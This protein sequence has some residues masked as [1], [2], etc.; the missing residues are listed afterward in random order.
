MEL[1]M[2]VACIAIRINLDFLIMRKFFL[3]LGIALCFFCSAFAQKEKHYEVLDEAKLIV[4][5]NLIW[6]DDSTNL[7]L[8]KQEDM[9]LLIGND[10]SS[11]QSLGYYRY[12]EFQ[13]M[14]PDASAIEYKVMVQETASNFSYRI[15][16]NYPKN[17][18]TVMER[19]P[20]MGY[21][22]YDEDLP[23]F[24]WEI[25]E[26]TIRIEGYLAQKA[27]CQYS[28]RTWEAWF[29]E[30]LPFND[31][32]Y[33]FCGLPGLILNMI[34]SK[35]DYRFYFQSIEVPEK[36][37]TIKWENKE[38]VKTTKKGLFK[39]IDNAAESV[40][41]N[42][43]ERTSTEAQKNIYYGMKANNNPIELDRK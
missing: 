37:T 8:G 36:G 16:K 35:K 39:V 38:T 15:Y 30:E 22:E 1:L 27:V 28:G 32:P 14:S 6:R 18:I 21:F 17:R 10:I 26:D 20:F 25:M 43:D 4:N 11:F 7:K 3:S 33:K 13:M 23:D 40:M 12:R 29:T 34:D 5:Y 2:R 19:V 9:I 42:F 41:R 24:D 31:G